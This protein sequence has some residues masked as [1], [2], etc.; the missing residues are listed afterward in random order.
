MIRKAR[1]PDLEA[2]AQIYEE[3]H[4]A[5]EKEQIHVGWIRGI[6]PVMETAVKALN[7]DDLFVLEHGGTVAGSGIINHIQMDAYKSAPWEHQV[8]DG[9]VLVLHTLVILPQFSNNG[10]GTEFIRFYEQ[11]AVEYHCN[12]LRIDTNAIN[13]TARRM[14]QKL[15]YKEIAVVPTEFNG[16]PDVNLVLLEKWLDDGLQIWAGEEKV[17]QQSIGRRKD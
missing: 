14:Y 1:K 10:L 13:L 17:F 8:P 16:I 4:L 5:E 15:G 11:Y 3:L 2:V 12:E 6:Y 7:R 9:Q